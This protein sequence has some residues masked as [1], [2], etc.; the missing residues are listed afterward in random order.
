MGLCMSSPVLDV[1]RLNFFA[2]LVGRKFFI[3]IFPWL[4]MSSKS[5]LLYHFFFFNFLFCYKHHSKILKALWKEKHII[6]LDFQSVLNTYP[7]LPCTQQD[8]QK[9]QDFQVG[10]PAA[11]LI[12]I[13][14]VASWLFLCRQSSSQMWKNS[15]F[16]CL[17][18]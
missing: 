6:V 15:S 11:M 18:G 8:D 14:W 13:Y 4:M 1:V 5:L 16:S 12:F 9:K 2:S 10:V 7:L 3:L 17:V